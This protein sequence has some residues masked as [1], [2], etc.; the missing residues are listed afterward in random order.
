MNEKIDNIFRDN[1][2]NVQVHPAQSVK[3][4]LVKEVRSIIYRKALFSIAIITTS[5][6]VL[7]ITS[8]LVFQN[9]NKGSND[10]SHDYEGQNTGLLSLNNS[11][12]QTT[13]KA[14]NTED[15][16]DLESIEND[17]PNKLEP[18]PP[19]LLA[20]KS[21]AT[22]ADLLTNSQSNYS[23]EVTTEARNSNVFSLESTGKKTKQ[24]DY[25]I[26]NEI[27]AIQLI[28]TQKPQLHSEPNSK[29]EI[30]AME[31]SK[32]IESSNRK[33]KEVRPTDKYSQSNTQS[34][35]NS[36]ETAPELTHP[37]FST[38]EGLTQESSITYDFH[39]TIDASNELRELDKVYSE[40][41][42]ELG[43][44]PTEIHNC[45]PFEIGSDKKFWSIGIAS[46]YGNYSN[47]LNSSSQNA[48][49]QRATAINSKSNYLGVFTSRELGRLKFSLGTGIERMSQSYSV[50]TISRTEEEIGSYVDL[51]E[52][53]I[54]DGNPTQVYV[55]Q[56]YVTSLVEKEEEITSGLTNQIDYLQ[57]P[58]SVGYDLFRGSRFDAGF[59]AGII[60][61]HQL[62]STGYVLNELS[63]VINSLELDKSLVNKS[64]WHYQMGITINRSIT[65]RI[66]VRV[67]P[68]LRIASSTQ[69]DKLRIQ[70]T[71]YSGLDINFG[72]QIKL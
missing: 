70:S 26:T 56:E 36:L 61:N 22:N 39:K 1:L 47:S 31:S 12:E 41:D 50:S 15:D 10:V 25:S 48:D 6:S 35:L 68:R 38:E 71:N 53:V 49:V 59:S 51:Y 14:I 45:N 21:P 11:L 55:G 32:T 2:G 46:G 62:N 52:V 33:P 7:V 9:A 65:Q 16:F 60:Y 43:N 58:F 40:L 69:F 4:G 20:Q 19:E 5:V 29:N 17:T 8:S 42:S 57:I 64:L 72:L 44:T 63:G 54:I 28:K 37:R 67:N 27:T 24:N 23:K 30:T 34:N 18:N 3:N 13:S 66:S